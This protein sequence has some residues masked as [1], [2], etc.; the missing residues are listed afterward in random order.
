MHSWHGAY[1]GGTGHAWEGA[2]HTHRPEDVFERLITI[3]IIRAAFTLMIHAEIVF[4]P[5]E[6]SDKAPF[7]PCPVLS[8]GFEERRCSMC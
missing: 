1:A 6:A 2:A 3:S 7:I 4:V 8:V 5:A